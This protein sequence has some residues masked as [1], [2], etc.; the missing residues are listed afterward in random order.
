M[1]TLLLKASFVIIILLV[2]YKI[3]LEKESFFGANRVYLLGC[4]VL[5]FVLPFVSLP[6]LVR[7]QGFISKKI[8]QLEHSSSNTS[9]QEFLPKSHN[10]ESNSST[11]QAAPRSQE[12]NAA[13]HEKGVLYWLSLIYY[14]GVLVL[15][16]NLIT[17]MV[18]LFIKI[19]KSTEKIRDTDCTI[20]NTSLIKEP[21]SFFNYIFI[22]PEK[23]D[24]DTYEQIIAHEKIHVQ[25]GHT[26]DLLLSE[27]AIVLLW[28]NP[29]IWLFRKEIEKN[30]E[31]QT[32]ALLVAKT[33][34]PKESYQMNLLKIAT[35]Q[36]PLAI[37]TNYNQSLIKKRILKMSTKKSNPH[38]NWKYAFIVPVLFALLLSMNMP[39]DDISLNDGEES[40][41]QMV[42]GENTAVVDGDCQQLLRAVKSQNVSRVKELLKT[43]DP[44]C[45][46][47]GDGEPR[48]PL[49]AA[50]RKGNLEI[51]KLLVGAKADVAYHDSADESPLIAASAN[52][53]L[54]FVIY[55]MEKGADV[56]RKVSGDGT[57]L[58]VASRGGHLEIVTYLISKNADVNARV[59]GDGTPLICA[60][61]NGHYDIAKLLLENNADP[62]LSSPGDEYPMYH[63]RMANNKRMIALLKKYE[64][65]N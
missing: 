4:L 20:V 28:F 58:L 41:I 56:N 22:D 46:Y 40:I 64:S 25:K 57:A 42:D 2:F 5:M 23:Y 3:V 36:K 21:C 62:Y 54:D 34:V 26:I 12:P 32:D 65:E 45:R 27:M 61:R 8:A 16:L 6:K 38:N 29:L 24:Y 63:A 49:V 60:T 50:A 39:M 44:D 10:T 47:R 52:G 37:T 19:K 17:Q 7:D 53:H 13:Y 9:H 11:V 48:T 33:S 30:I 35:L 59:S 18:S 43:V 15:S 1:L 55:L 51:G 31:Y 14:F